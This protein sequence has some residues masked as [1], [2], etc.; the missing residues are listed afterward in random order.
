ML[1]NAIYGKPCLHRRIWNIPRHLCAL[2]IYAVVHC[3]HARRAGYARG[4]ARADVQHV[5]MD[6]A[7]GARL[8]VV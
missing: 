5:T 4:V 3:D 2:F 1:V 8:V 6:G 7:T